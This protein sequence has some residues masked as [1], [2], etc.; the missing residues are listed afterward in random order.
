MRSSSSSEIYYEPKAITYAG[1]AGGETGTDDDASNEGITQ[2]AAFSTNIMANNIF[3][4]RLVL[5]GDDDGDMN[6][7]IDWGCHGEMWRVVSVIP[8]VWSFSDASSPPGPA[9]VGKKKR[10]MER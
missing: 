9:V 1:S 8:M 3:S 5:P 6:L 4:W 10:R 2:T 7:I